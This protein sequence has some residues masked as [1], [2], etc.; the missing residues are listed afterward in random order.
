MTGRLPR[1]L[2]TAYAAP[3]LPLAAMYLPAYMLVANHYA[4]NFGLSLSVLGLCLVGIRIA[5]AVSDPL[6][7]YLS[8]RTP[9]RFG[10]R[11]IW[12][13]ASVPVAVGGALALFSPPGTPGVAWFALAFLAL[14]LGWSMAITP[15]LSWGAELSG[16]YGER[17]RVSIWRESVGLAGTVGAALAYGSGGAAGMERVAWLI[18]LCMPVAVL[19]LV[20]RVPEP[21]DLSR[22]TPRLADVLSVLRAEPVFRR[23]IVAQFL[24]GFANG[25]AATLFVLFVSWRL[26]RPDLAG[27]LLVAYF[28]AAALA[29][30]F[31]LRVN[32]AM[33]KH[34]LWSL[35]MIYAG[36]VVVFTATLGPGD[37]PF[38]L[39]IC[40]LSGAALGADL[41]MPAAIQADLVDIATARSGN[42]QT[43]A[44]FALWS[45]V[46]KLAVAISGGL[47]LAL[48]GLAGFVAGEGSTAFGETA[49]T[50]LYAF[51]PIAFKG[52]AIALMWNFPVD[53]E[54]QRRLRR[55]IEQA[56]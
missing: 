20:L 3:A 47:A 41:A 2:L 21:R 54:A 7:G 48:L 9:A 13:M 10:R 35:A 40:L 11:R 8:D 12:V 34:R 4:A 43:G 52:A 26:D 49:L 37:W 29:G 1:T 42:Q 30:P 50:L 27:P 39:A 33:P 45:L 56:G 14:T 23:L 51:G 44:F 25:I 6:V 55:T 32:G 24:N 17:A 22:S 38:F 53:E 31:W 36:C 18:A 5:D 19:L 46:N 15:Y 16:D 28:A